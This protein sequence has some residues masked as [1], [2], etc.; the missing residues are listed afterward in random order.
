[1]GLN[2]NLQTAAITDSSGKAATEVTVF[3]ENVMSLPDISNKASTQADFMHNLKGRA[4]SVP[5]FRNTRNINSF[6]QSRLGNETR[7]VSS[8][9]PSIET[10]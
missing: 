9:E 4:I 5:R 3:N 8:M 7:N 1:L 10:Y 6:E 2:P